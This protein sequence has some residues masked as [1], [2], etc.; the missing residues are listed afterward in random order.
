MVWDVRNIGAG[1]LRRSKSMDG[2]ANNLVA[3]AAL[4]AQVTLV[5]LLALVGRCRGRSV[6]TKCKM[7]E[8]TL[9]HRGG[10]RKISNGYHPL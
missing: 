3:Q 2:F 8:H 7:Y 6:F 4:V 9:T 5:A 10:K 1:K